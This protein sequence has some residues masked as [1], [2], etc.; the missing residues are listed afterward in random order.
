M[1]RLVVH[2]TN[3]GTDD[4][5]LDGYGVSKQHSDVHETVTLGAMLGLFA[6]AWVVMGTASRTAA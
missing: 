3:I 6:A 2:A 5:S 4:A 1:S